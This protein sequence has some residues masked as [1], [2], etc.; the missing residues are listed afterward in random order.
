MPSAAGVAPGEDEQAASGDPEQPEL[1]DGT[2]IGRVVE[3]VDRGDHRQAAH[4]PDADDR[5]AP[6]APEPVA[7]VEEPGEEDEHGRAEPDADL[8][9]RVAAHEP[10]ALEAGQ[11]LGG[12]LEDRLARPGADEGVDRDPGRGEQPDRPAREQSTVALEAEP[13]RRVVRRT[14]RPR[15]GHAIPIDER[16]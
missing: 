14:G 16:S 8:R 10:L 12:E 6:V 7:P 13:M 3:P 11:R 1:D 5:G 15:V 2:L 9:R 4:D